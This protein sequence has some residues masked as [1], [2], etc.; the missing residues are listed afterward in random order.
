[1]SLGISDEHRELGDSLRKWAGS[2]GAIDEVRAAEHDASAAFGQTWAALVEMGVPAIGVPEGAGGGGGSVLD[3]AVALEA[4]AHRML[5]GPLL[6]T[7]VAAALLGETSDVAG[8]LARG[9]MSVGLGLVP[10]LTVDDRTVSG[11]VDVVWDAPSV[12][13]L[14]LG[15]SGDRWF[16]VPSTLAEVTPSIG[17]DLSRR[18]GSVDLVAVPLSDVVEVPTIDAA[19]LRR[20]A[21]TLAAAEAAGVARWCL[22]T[23]VEYAGVRE[24]FGAKIGSFQAIKQLCAGMLETAEAVTAV[25]WDA[26]SIAFGDDD[27]W[28]FAADVAG[29]IA[30]DGAVQVAQ[31]CIQVLGGIGFTFEHDAHFYLRRATTLRALLGDS[32]TFAASLTDAAA[33]GVRRSVRLDFEGE[34]EPVRE[35]IRPQASRLAALEGEA[36]RR[37]LVESGLFMPHWP[38]PWGQDASPLEQLVIDQE[39]AAAGVARADLK[40]G[41]WAV[42]TILA[43]G[44]EAQREQ[45][46]RPTLRGEIVWCQLFSEPGAGSDLASLRTRAVKVEGGWRLTGQKVW[47]SLAQDAHWAICLGR[48][49]PEAP[50]HKGITYFLLDMSS[51]GI[52]VRPLR[53]LTGDALFN[54]V[55]LDDVFVPD[56]CVV[57]EVDNGWRLARTTLANERVAMAG[58]KL[59]LSVER[60]VALAGGVGA[61]QRARIGHAV[62]LATVCSLL[63]VRTTL[64]SLAGAGPGAESSVAKLLTVRNRQDGSEL[65]VDLLG[66]RV[67]LGGEEVDAAV[68][69]MLLTRCLSIAGGT[70]QIL[71]NVAAERILGLPR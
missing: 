17:P 33:N 25:A 67:V 42:P 48:T 64:R 21:V 14:L 39:L 65:V 20:T 30:F 32:D 1:M 51:T 44:S 31:D 60:A 3:V 27:Q 5:P 10:S 50:Q 55:F 9:E 69:E 4:C 37:G 59:D 34:D 45:F 62:A 13:H 38:T 35:R 24:Q 54:E 43:H 11:H 53:E 18:F 40:I 71:R 29:T 28:A 22:D 15:A 46:V 66:D 41:G 63:G 49:N 70:T 19:L 47:T 61:A 26:A 8:A 7:A 23:A 58:T 2:L 12:T 57:G 56:D 16:V 6:G 52:D 36:Q 68:H